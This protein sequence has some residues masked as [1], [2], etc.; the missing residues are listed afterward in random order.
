RLVLVTRGAMGVTDG[1]APDPARAA[2]WGL[3]RSAQSEHPDRFVLV[4]LDERTG[5]RTIDWPALLDADEP[6]LAV[7]RGAPYVLRVARLDT[8]P[9]LAPP[10]EAEAWHLDAP[11]RGTLEDLALVESPEATRPLGA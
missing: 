6:Q 8:S 2:L 10:A 9:A 11:Q 7:R 3:V 1:E 5:A 4:D